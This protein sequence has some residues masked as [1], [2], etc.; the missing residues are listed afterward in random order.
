MEEDKM[1][2]YWHLAKC[3]TEGLTENDHSYKF[4]AFSL[5]LD[6]IIAFVVV[7]TIVKLM[8]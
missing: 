2:D 8:S 4:V 6:E 7:I 5:I 1:R 3:M